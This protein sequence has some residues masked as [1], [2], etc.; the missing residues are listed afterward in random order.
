MAR[1]VCEAME[2]WGDFGDLG[3]DMAVERHGRIWLL[4]VNRGLQVHPLAMFEGGEAAVRRVRPT[5]LPYAR[6]LAGWPPARP[7]AGRS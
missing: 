1:R 2:P 5:L 7:A 6:F 3:L 4:E